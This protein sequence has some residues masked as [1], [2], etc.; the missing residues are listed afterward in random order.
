MRHGRKTS[1]KRFN[2]YKR[3]LAADLDARLIVACAVTPANRPEGEAAPELQADIERQGLTVGEL[4]I[5]RGYINSRLVDD[6]LGRRGEVFCKPWVPQNTN[7]QFTKAQ[8]RLNL[9]AMTITCPAGEVEPITWGEVVEF[10]SGACDECPMRRQC[11]SRSVGH[12]R[13]VRIADDERLQQRLR[14]R[15]ATRPGREQLRQRVAVEHKLAHISQRQ[16][17][18]ARY[19]GVRSNLYDLRR[20]ASIQNLETTQRQRAA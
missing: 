5:D 9:R 7:G 13:Q 6:V 2:G 10:D 18:R 16:G 4:Y 14:K 17:R 12:G 3:H 19:F 11:T 1:S 8:F 20:A 15:I